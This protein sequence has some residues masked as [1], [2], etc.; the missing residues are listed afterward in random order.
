[1]DAVALDYLLPG[2]NGKK[3]RAE[4]APPALTPSSSFCVQAVSRRRNPWWTF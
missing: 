3:A 2:M 4:S 1:V